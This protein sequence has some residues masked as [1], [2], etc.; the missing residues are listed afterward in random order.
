MKYCLFIMIT[1][2][3]I[4]V[5]NGDCCKPPIYAKAI[6]V[7]PQGIAKPLAPNKR[8]LINKIK[9]APQKPKSKP[10]CPPGRG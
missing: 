3:I 5:A 4:N 7:Y 2:L 8:F 10:K 9:P 1:F 6:P